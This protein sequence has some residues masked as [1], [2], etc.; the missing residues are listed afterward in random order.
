MLL[1]TSK[2]SKQSVARA[3]FFIGLLISL[4][5]TLL[6]FA[7]FQFIKVP[8]IIKS[9]EASTLSSFEQ[10]NGKLVSCFVVTREILQGQTII[11]GDLVPVDIPS[12]SIPS[13]SLNRSDAEGKVTRMTLAVGSIVTGSNLTTSLDYIND[14]VRKQE[15]KQIKLMTGLVKDQYVDVRVKFDDGRDYVVLSKKRILDIINNVPFLSRDEIELGYMNSA[16][17]EAVIS[18][19][20]F[21][22]VLYVDPQNQ[23]AAKVTYKPS[24]Q[25][26]K[27]IAS[28]PNVV[29]ESTKKLDNSKSTPKPTATPKTEVPTATTTVVPQSTPKPVDKPVTITTEP[30]STEDKTE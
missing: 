26:L 4:V 11:A 7:Y 8:Q 3:Y 16:T 23:P 29:T 13:D 20:E 12:K 22:T 5:G 27:A 10:K 28:D 18:K 30:V 21:Y 6:V 1:S 14:D 25:I 17:V 19:G 2:M 15:F 24:E 9:S